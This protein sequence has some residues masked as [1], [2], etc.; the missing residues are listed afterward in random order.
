M[1]TSASR[2]WAD[3]GIF[4]PLDTSSDYKIVFLVRYN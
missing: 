2:V 1:G 4:P 3:H